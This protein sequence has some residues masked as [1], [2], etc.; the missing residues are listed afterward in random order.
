MLA[1]GPAYQNDIKDVYLYASVRGTTQQQ[2][3]LIFMNATANINR[4][5]WHYKFYDVA[6]KKIRDCKIWSPYDQF[7]GRSLT[8]T[9][10]RDRSQQYVVALN[11]YRNKVTR[12][13]RYHRYMFNFDSSHRDRNLLFV[14]DTEN[15]EYIGSDENYHFVAN[16]RFLRYKKNVSSVNRFLHDF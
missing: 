1:K 16:D 2:T 3:T 15:D 13:F 9:N 11:E 6:E 5:T 14:F 7:V 4:F 12:E 10:L 8:F